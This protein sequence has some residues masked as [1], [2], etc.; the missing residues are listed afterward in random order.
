M[1]NIIVNPVFELTLLALFAFSFAI[2]FYLKVPL[3]A[4]STAA[5]TR[6]SV[7]LLLAGIYLKFLFHYDKLWL[8]LLWLI[9]IFTVAT[10]TI[11]HRSEF[12]LKKFF[13][14]VFLSFSISTFLNT[15]LL[16]VWVIQLKTPLSARYLIPVTGMIAG[17]SLRA[18]ITALRTFHQGLREREVLWR[19][20]FACGANPSEAFLGLLQKAMNDAVQ[21]IV[22]SVATMGLVFLPGFMTGSIISG[23][24]SS[25][26]VFYQA[27]L[28]VSFFANSI[29]SSFLSLFFVSRVA[30]KE[31][32]VNYSE[33]KSAV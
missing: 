26:A 13:L 19:Y 2:L 7:Q 12:A 24:D 11:L 4:S 31:A 30:A 33:K 9:I 8:N 1:T 29:I 27:V 6:M 21:P 3:I 5:F 23:E 16:L 17:N 20:Y 10:F 32:F 18:T 28:M 22:A 25:A 14:P 15:L